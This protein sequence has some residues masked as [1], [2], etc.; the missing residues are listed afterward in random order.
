MVCPKCGSEN[1]KVQ[2]VT[3]T[4]LV[5]QHHSVIW[6]ICV[7]WWWMMVKWLFLTLPA[8]IIKIFSPKKQKMVV[9]HKNMCVC[10][11][12]GNSWEVPAGK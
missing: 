12:C 2:M 6:W 5:A 3:E 7:G 4:Q 10:Q 8:L 9:T 11:N 1:V